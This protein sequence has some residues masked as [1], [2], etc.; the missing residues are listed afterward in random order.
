MEENEQLLAR[1]LG[2]VA[3]RIKALK[4]LKEL[5]WFAGECFSTSDDGSTSEQKDEEKR[6]IFPLSFQTIKIS[7]NPICRK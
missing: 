3:S 5:S 6:N 4:N 1:Q 7:P 2:E